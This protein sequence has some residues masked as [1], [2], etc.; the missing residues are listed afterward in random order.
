M[1]HL[2]EAAGWQIPL[3]GQSGTGKDGESTSVCAL[4]GSFCSYEAIRFNLETPDD[5]S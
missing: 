4:P 3:S 5:L 1:P 2:T